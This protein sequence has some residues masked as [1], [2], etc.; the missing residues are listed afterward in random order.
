MGVT[1]PGPGEQQ[2]GAPST[3]PQLW[4]TELRE[5]RTPLIHPQ[6]HGV[7]QCPGS[8]SGGGS[9][10]TGGSRESSVSGWGGSGVRGEQFQPQPRSQP[11]EHGAAV[12]E[13]IPKRCGAPG[14]CLRLRSITW[15]FLR[16]RGAPL[17]AQHCHPH[18]TVPA[19]AGVEPLPQGPEP[20]GLGVDSSKNN[21][22][23]GLS[24]RR[25]VTIAS[26]SPCPRS[27]EDFAAR[28]R[29]AA[30]QMRRQI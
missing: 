26:R 18:P 14:L 15:S 20:R 6:P 9:G 5:D 10:G 22:L 2:G 24:C 7:P 8:S 16:A 29:L 12:G 27:P 21:R 1:L 3:E 19:G 23:L 28:C 30:M 25:R 11:G 4:Q 13:G 17:R